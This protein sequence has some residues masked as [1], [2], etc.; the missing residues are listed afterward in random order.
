MPD[1]FPAPFFARYSSKTREVSLHQTVKVSA[2]DL[3][4]LVQELSHLVQ[5]VHVL[6]QDGF[7]LVVSAV[8]NCTNLF[9]DLCRYRFGVVAGVSKVATQK[10]LVFVLSVNDWTQAV[11]EAIAGHHRLGNLG[12]TL[13]VVGSTGRNII[14]HQFFCNASAQQG[15]DIFLLPFL[16]S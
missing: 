2:V 10:D 7:A 11:A 12:R 3:F 15:N 13:Q 4:K 6:G 14:Q 16:V 8:D 9:V 5:L 1:W